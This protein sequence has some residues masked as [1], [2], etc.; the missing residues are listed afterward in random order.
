LVV[1]AL[2]TSAAEAATAE[3]TRGQGTRSRLV[4]AAATPLSETSRLTEVE[5]VELPTTRRLR[6][7]TAVTVDPVVV[8]LAKPIVEV[9]VAHQR[10]LRQWNSEVTVQ[11]GSS[12]LSQLVQLVAAVVVQAALALLKGLVA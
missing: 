8:D 9:R 7:E 10:E 2:A 4:E 11:Q 6:S 12:P 5:V 3:M 1:V